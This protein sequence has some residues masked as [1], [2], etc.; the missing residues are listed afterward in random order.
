MLSTLPKRNRGTYLDK[1]TNTQLSTNLFKVNF[2]EETK[3]FIYSFKTLPEIPRENVHKVRSMLMHNRTIVER[4]VGTYAI[5]GRTVFGSKA[6]KME[7]GAETD[8]KL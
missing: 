8:F 2:K 3:V 6:S 5:S 7:K 4:V 1:Y